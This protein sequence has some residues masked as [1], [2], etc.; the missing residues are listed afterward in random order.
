M[1]R[2]RSDLD[3][4]RSRAPGR[5]TAGNGGLS[6]CTGNRR[7]RSWS[8][9][10]FDFS[11]F[12]RGRHAFD[13]AD[14]FVRRFY[15]ACA[16]AT[17]RCP[18]ELRPGSLPL[19]RQLIDDRHRRRG[20]VNRRIADL[21][22]GEARRPLAPGS[23]IFV[24]PL[25]KRISTSGISLPASFPKGATP[26][27]HRRIFGAARLEGLTDL[28]RAGRLRRFPPEQVAEVRGDRLRAAGHPRPAARLLHPH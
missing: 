15:G 8:E 3:F 16:F 11:C 6:R 26:R 10:H 25:S 21:G 14:D 17:P 24:S 18:P 27:A 5:V 22:D 28:Q 19:P 1:R 9:G 12:V 7:L 23:R 20:G 2:F 13:G 4:L